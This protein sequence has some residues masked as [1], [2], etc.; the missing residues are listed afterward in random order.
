MR[1]NHVKQVRMAHKR[2]HEL[3]QEGFDEYF[4]FLRRLLPLVVRPVAQVT[5]DGGGECS[6]ARGET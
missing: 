6:L 1:L 3:Y 5:E 4:N 2:C